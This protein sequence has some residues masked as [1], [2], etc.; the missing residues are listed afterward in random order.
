MLNGSAHWVPF[1]LKKLSI[2]GTKSLV[3]NAW[4]TAIADA[5]GTMLWLS[6]R[7]WMSSVSHCTR[8]GSLEVPPDSAVVY[9]V[10]VSV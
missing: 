4:S 10:R 6:I 1:T 8:S 2:E 9:A 5:T 7:S 3:E